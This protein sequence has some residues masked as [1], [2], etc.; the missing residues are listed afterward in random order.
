M[1]RPMK[2][3]AILPEMT[4]M[5]TCITSQVMLTEKPQINLLFFQ[6]GFRPRSGLPSFRSAVLPCGAARHPLHQMHPGV[7]E[8]GSVHS[9]AEKENPEVVPGAC[10]VVSP[11]DF[12]ARA[13]GVEGFGGNRKAKLNVSFDLARMGCVVEK[14]ELNRS[15]SPHIVEVD[16]A[17][18]CPV[19]MLRHRGEGSEPGSVQ[20]V[21]SGRFGFFEA[22]DELAVGAAGIV[23]KA[24]FQGSGGFQNQLFLLVE[25]PRDVG[26]LSGGEVRH[27]DVNMLACAFRRFGSG[28]AQSP[29]NF[30]QGFHVVPFQNRGDHLGAAAAVG[31]T[32]VADRLPDSAVRRGCLPGVVGSADVLHCSAYHAVNRP[33]RLLAGDSGVLQ[34]RPEGQNLR[35][36]NNRAAG[37]FFLHRFF[38][39]FPLRSGIRTAPFTVSQYAIKSI[40]N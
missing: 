36:L 15:G 31:Q 27:T 25:N 23:P 16:G 26:N 35:R 29:D 4:A 37:H 28:F 33:C 7:L 6:G 18:S 19:I 34:F 1:R 32:A 8:F 39:R 21:L 10:L 20:L 9:E 3:S 5:E 14:T 13:L 40:I 30:L 22:G 38:D 2:I 24:A 12:G 17:V 11:L